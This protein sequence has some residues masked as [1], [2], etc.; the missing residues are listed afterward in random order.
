MRRIVTC[1]FANNA[2]N[3]SQRGAVRSISGSRSDRRECIKRVVINVSWECHLCQRVCVCERE[4]E[5]KREHSNS[6]SMFPR[7]LT[8]QSMLYTEDSLRTWHVRQLLTFV[9]SAA[10]GGFTTDMARASATNICP[11]TTYT[12]CTI[13]TICEYLTPEYQLS[14]LHDVTES[15]KSS[16]WLTY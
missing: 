10:H 11:Q 5:S 2:I 13:N 12:D 4:R 8:Y 16:Q 15:V 7:E 6:L 1:Y 14:V 3:T 9:H